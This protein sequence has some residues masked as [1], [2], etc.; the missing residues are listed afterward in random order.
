MYA[1]QIWSQR[2]CLSGDIAVS[3]DLTCLHF[4]LSD[5]AKECNIPG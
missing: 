1:M 5:E 2:K 4:V 3:A